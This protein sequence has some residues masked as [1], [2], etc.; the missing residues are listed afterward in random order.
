MSLQLSKLKNF[1]MK[2][3]EDKIVDYKQIK[4]YEFLMLC[5]FDDTNGFWGED[6]LYYKE[7]L[8]KLYD[9]IVNGKE[10][11]LKGQMAS[12]KIYKDAQKDHLMKWQSKL[13]PTAYKALCDWVEEKNEEALKSTQD[14]SKTVVRGDDLALFI[15]NYEG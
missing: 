7:K 3:R 12:F 8:P 2:S 14:F 4:E 13:N 6:V 5:G 15:K 11:K 9:Y 1:T 10:V